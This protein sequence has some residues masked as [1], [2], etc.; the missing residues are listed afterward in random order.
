MLYFYNNTHATYN[1]RV[2]LY[3][4]NIAYLSGKHIPLFLVV[5]LVFLFLF[6]LVP[7]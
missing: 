4:A 2:W 1:K 5:V 7:D 6:L 3:D